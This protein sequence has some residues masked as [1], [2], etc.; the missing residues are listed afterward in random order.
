MEELFPTDDVLSDESKKIIKLL[1]TYQI[2]QSAIL[3]SE[4][5]DPT[6][7]SNLQINKEMRDTLDHL[8]R[9]YNHKLNSQNMN[10]DLLN[11]NYEK[12]IG[13][14]YR[15]TFDALDGTVMSVSELISHSLNKYTAKVLSEVIPDYWKLRKEILSI[16]SKGSNFRA[17]KDVGEKSNEMLNS[18]IAEVDVLDGFYKEILE[19]GP[20]L[21]EYEKQ[22][23]GQNIKKR[24]IDISVAIIATVI[25]GLILV[26]VL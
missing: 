7:A 23:R 1:E 22:L 4:E 8:M 11:E 16:K 19:N 25:G 13:H 9:I 10:R 17:Y 24:I 15:A 3:Y 18:Y 20:Q 6:S 14:L 5:V 2:A 21:D 12:A 26:K